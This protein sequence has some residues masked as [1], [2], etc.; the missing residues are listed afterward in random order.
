MNGLERAFNPRTVVVVGDK[1]GQGFFWL[2]SL[3]SFQGQVYSVQID[4]NEIPQIEELGYTNYSSLM[5]V[6]GDVDY[7]IVSVPQVAAMSVV[8]DC[9]RKKVGGVTLFTS[10]FAET[11]T[12]QGR[13]AQE[14]LGRVA[15]EG[16][17][18]LIGPNCMGIFHPKI[19]LRFSVEQYFGEGGRVGFISQSGTHVGQM[20][21]VGALH[22]VRLSKGVS[23]GNAVVLDSPAYLEYLVKDEETDIIGMYLEGVKDG[24]SLFRLLREAVYRK[25][26]VVWKGGETEDGRRAV[27]SHTASLTRSPLIWE[28]ALR[29]AGAIPVRNLEE[30]VDT[31]KGLLYLKPPFGDRMGIVALSGGQSVVVSDAFARAG[32]KVPPLSTS[33]YKELEAFFSVVGASYRNPFDVSWQLPLDNLRRILD[34]LER[35]PNIDNIAIEVSGPFLA[36]RW[37]SRPGFISELMEILVEFRE[38]WDKP[39]LV[40]LTPVQQEAIAMEGRAEFNRMGLPSYASFDRAAQ[41]LKRVIDY[42][43]FLGEA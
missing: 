41:S 17:L 14:E 31:V 42:H 5:D 15:Q 28:A 16:G 35:D 3:K 26:V 7:V 24:A 4:P 20:A 10:A 19:G 27:M 40:M 8:R 22:G 21:V 12:K 25:P 38:K 43:R 33:S 39:L 13:D 37:E 34:I 18:T 1:K 9:I 32:L 6:P 2:K 30:M 23:F 11:G 29:Q 36:R